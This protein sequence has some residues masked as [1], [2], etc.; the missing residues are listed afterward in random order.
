MPNLF[1]Q[2]LK[3]LLE[4][5]NSILFSDLMSLILLSLF[6][7]ANKL[8]E[9]Q[10]KNVILSFFLGML[11]QTFKLQRKTK[12]WEVEPTHLGPQLECIIHGAKHI[13]MNPQN[14]IFKLVYLLF[15]KQI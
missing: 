14:S 2:E 12:R 13:L 8:L 3:K 7:L 4:C 1:N 10:L 5:F 6:S 15:M 11:P 9:F